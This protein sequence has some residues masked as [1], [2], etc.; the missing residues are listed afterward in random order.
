MRQKPNKA[1][2]LNGYQA[3]PLFN[4]E[5]HTRKPVVSIFNERSPSA[6]NRNR[7]SSWRRSDLTGVGDNV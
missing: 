1:K 4:N 3:E 6:I 7:V 5:R 2:W